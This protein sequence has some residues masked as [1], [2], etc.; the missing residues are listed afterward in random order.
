MTI[1]DIKFNRN[2][3]RNFMAELR[4]KV[5]LYFQEHNISRY[6]N[7]KM[8]VKT[9]ALIAAFATLYGI[10]VS[11]RVSHPWLLILLWGLMAIAT[12]GIGF[13]IMHDANH[14][15]Y[16]RNKFVNTTL[17]YLLNFIGGNALNWRIQHNVLH[18]S[19]TNVSGMDED[20]DAG[21]ILRFSPHQERYWFHRFQHIYAWVFYGMMTFMWITTKDIRQ[22]IRYSKMGLLS[23]QGV[24]FSWALVELVVTKLL[25][26]GYLLVIPMIMLDIPWYMTLLFFSMMHFILGFMTACVFQ[27]AHVVDDAA[28]PI[29]DDAGNLENSWAV[30]QLLTTTNFAPKS[31]IMSWFIGGLNYQIEHHLF[32]NICHI[33]YPKLSRIVR[34]TAERFGLPYHV[35]PTFLIALGNHAKM[36]RQLGRAD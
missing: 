36:L 6:A 34:E 32:P 1:Q 33:H 23:T 14:G 30:H 19:F 2:D 17:G 9:V 16:S 4:Q 26:Y 5:N 12:A 18:H 3:Q 11:G 13:S 7:R 20:I 21:K 25:Y 27:T 35:Q 28:Y 15:A 10:L 31:R 8:V 24:S 29:P 22:L